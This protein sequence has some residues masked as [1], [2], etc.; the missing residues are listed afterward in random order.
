MSVTVT[1]TILRR[2]SL[3]GGHQIRIVDL[4]MSGT[5]A[6]DGVSVEPKNV[7]LNSIEDLVVLNVGTGGYVGSVTPTSTTTSK[8]MVLY[9]PKKSVN[10][11]D[12]V[13][14]TSDVTPAAGAANGLASLPAAV[15]AV[16]GIVSSTPTNFKI[17]TQGTTPATGEVAVNYTTGVL[18][19]YTGDDPT[20]VTV[21]YIPQ[22]EGLAEVA[23][24][25]NIGTPTIR[26]MAIGY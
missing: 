18:T 22:V 26:V 19:F 20:E 13:T 3:V 25:T 23:N 12:A 2:G 9:T 15:L 16:H 24:G 6:T 5:Y 17:I 8:K 21:D 14:V 1:S 7:E 11:A 10:V 4:A